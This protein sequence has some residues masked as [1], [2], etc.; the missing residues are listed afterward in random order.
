[1]TTG[2]DRS[3]GDAARRERALVL[4]TEVLRRPD[5]VAP[6][7][8]CLREGAMF[9]MRRATKWGGGEKPVAAKVRRRR[10]RRRPLRPA[11]SLLRSVPLAPPLLPYA[12]APYAPT[13][14]RPYAPPKPSAAPRAH[15][16]A[17]TPRPSR[18]LGW[19]RV[20]PAHALFPGRLGHGGRG[21]H[22][23]GVG[24][25]REARACGSTSIPP[26]WNPRPHRRPRPHSYS[27]P[28]PHPHPHPHPRPL[29]HSNHARSATPTSSPTSW[30]CMRPNP[31]SPLSGVATPRAARGCSPSPTPS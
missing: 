7:R 11:S 23:G 31:P 22:R 1:M 6:S 12:P 9:E 25:H 2:V 5:L 14:L 17:S 3:V 18:L 4:F 20:R 30:Y 29:P 15:L 21:G 13:P 19:P 24:W 28:L 8:V 10:R 27:R 26:H 16:D